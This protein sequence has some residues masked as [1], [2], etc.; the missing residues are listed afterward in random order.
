VEKKFPS[1]KGIQVLFPEEGGKK[2]KNNPQTAKEKAKKGV[3]ATPY[4]K[5]G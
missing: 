5:G 2:K 1:S 3:I 4:K